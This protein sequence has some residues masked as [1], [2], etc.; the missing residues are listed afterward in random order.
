MSYQVE[1]VV[2]LLLLGWRLATK[3]AKDALTTAAKNNA[4]NPGRIRYEVASNNS[5]TGREGG[6]E[7]GR[8]RKRGREQESGREGKETYT[9]PNLRFVSDI[10]FVSFRFVS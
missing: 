3:V 5:A 7:G 2:M 1:M 8:E 10:F 9:R 4:Q 6:S